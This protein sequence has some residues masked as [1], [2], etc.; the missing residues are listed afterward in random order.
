MSR[1]RVVLRTAVAVFIC[2]MCVKP[3]NAQPSQAETNSNPND[4]FEI[5][6]RG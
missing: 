2:T 3:S 5:S 1:D 4:R 6:P